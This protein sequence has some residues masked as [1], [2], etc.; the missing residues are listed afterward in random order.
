MR[1]TAADNLGELTRLSARVE[2]LV[3]DLAANAASAT[4]QDVAAAYLT[5]L[6]GAL[7]SSGD[8]LSPATLDKV[9]AQ[10]LELFRTVCGRPS[11]TSGVVDPLSAA[12][13]TAM[14]QYCAAAGASG[15]SRVLA[16]GPLAAA[17]S[18]GSTEA[19][20]LSAMLLAA[21]AAAAADLL[22]A[23]GLL[24][25]AV[26]AAVRATRDQLVSEGVCRGQCDT[27]C[28]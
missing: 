23:A 4:D 19:R 7:R 5:A 21:V 28:C 20:E 13:V 9:E 27:D 12:L 3:S 11:G 26:E 1:L 15:L 18:S 10:L 6:R 17:G 16:A 2:Q 24:R 25:G 22:D 8:R 14:S